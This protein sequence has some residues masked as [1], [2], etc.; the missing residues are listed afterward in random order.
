VLI[1]PSFAEQDKGETADE[2]AKDAAS[3]RENVAQFR[4]CARLARSGALRSE[5]HDEC[6]AFAPERTPREKSFLTYQM[7][8]PARYETMA[9]EAESQHSAD[10]RSDVN[11][12]QEISARRSF[13]SMPVTVLTAAL[14]A[15]T[16]T[17]TPERAL[18]ER[19]WRSWKAGHDALA[20]RSG[21]GRSLVVPDSGHFIQLDQPSALHSAIS[22]MVKAVRKP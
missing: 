11:S 8:R 12:G 3:F 22:E 6:F 19:N 18:A 1:D 7:V 2:L 5:R 16:I 20:A 21:Q 9:S 14:A 4:A 15:D 17:S 13:G 10:G